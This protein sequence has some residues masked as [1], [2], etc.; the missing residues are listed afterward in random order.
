MPAE[1][2]THCESVD[3]EF[4]RHFGALHPELPADAGRHL[5]ECD[6]CRNLYKY[7][8]APAPL[9][10]PSPGLNDRIG[11]TLRSSLKPVRPVAATR[12]VATQFFLLFVLLTIPASGMMDLMGWRLMSPGQVTAVTAVLIAGAALLS[13]SLAWQMT[14]GSLQRIPANRAMWIL[15]VSFLVVV[16]ILFPWHTPEGFFRLGWRCL[17]MGLLMAVPAAALF[18]ILLRRGA[19]LSPGA[20]GGT[21]GAISGLLGITVLQFQCDTQDAIHLL[22]WHG[23]V[24]VISASIGFLI[25][26]SVGGL[27]RY[28]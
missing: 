23:A 5:E 2:K 25:G 7:L 22:V 6:R 10:L 14:P 16:A 9:V 21:L 17:K 3:A 19:A 11:Q 24:V 1:T 28:D 26:R 8:S 27:R 20:L 4:D 13:L 12:I 18:G 15:S